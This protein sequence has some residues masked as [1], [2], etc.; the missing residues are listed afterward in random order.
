VAW[1]EPLKDVYMREGGSTRVAG[2]S[3]SLWHGRKFTVWQQESLGGGG[4]EP[5]SCGQAM[6]GGGGKARSAGG[7]ESRTT[8]IAGNLVVGS[9][10]PKERSIA[11]RL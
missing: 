10:Q 2:G 3:L 1:D 9:L 6:F 11:A 7:S 4:G 5:L 8:G